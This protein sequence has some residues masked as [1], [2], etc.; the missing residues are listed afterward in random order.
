MRLYQNSFTLQISHR[1]PRNL[2]KMPPKKHKIT[3]SSFKQ[4]RIEKYITP[5]ANSILANSSRVWPVNHFYHRCLRRASSRQS[6]LTHSHPQFPRTT[7][8]TP[9]TITPIRHNNTTT[10]NCL[11][12]GLD[13]GNKM[14]I[15]I[16]S[17][18]FA[19]LA[20]PVTWPKV[21]WVRLYKLSSCLSV[22][23]Y[24]TSSSSLHDMMF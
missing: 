19:V 1:V 12:Y 20:V 18:G 8:G 23:A 17:S 24:Y 11:D 10:K 16:F 15:V 3:R 4:I 7:L 2:E 5:L 14:V 13:Y 22:F 21:W 9:G 6:M